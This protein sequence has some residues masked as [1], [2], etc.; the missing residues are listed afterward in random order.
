MLF[1]TFSSVIW[2]LFWIL[3]QKDKRDEITKLFWNFAFG[4]IYITI[5]IVF[6]SEFKIPAYQGIIAVT[7]VGFFELGITF[8]LWM[9]ALQLT[10]SND[11]I[12]NLVFLSPFLALIFISLILKEKMYYTT[13]VGLVVIISGIFVQQYKKRIRN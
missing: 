1:A 13:I 9:K 12:S 5:T 3:N 7:Y 11:K 10:S 2:A 8:V 6:F 4:L